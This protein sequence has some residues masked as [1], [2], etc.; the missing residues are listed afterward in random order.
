MSTCSAFKSSP[1]SV[2]GGRR[3]TRPSRPSRTCKRVGLRGGRVRVRAE[4]RV[5]VRLGVRGRGRVSGQ[6]QG[7]GQG[8]GPAAR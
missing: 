3:T 1:R 8:Q 2:T 7:Q 5:G 4:V 6:G